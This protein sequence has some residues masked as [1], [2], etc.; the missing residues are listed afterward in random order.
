LRLKDNILVKQ[1]G[2]LQQGRIVNVSA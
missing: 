2:F 1:F